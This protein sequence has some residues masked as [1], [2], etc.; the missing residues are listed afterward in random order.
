MPKNLPSLWSSSECAQ[1][2]SRG[3]RV[4]LECIVWIA[5]SDLWVIYESAHSVL[6][7]C[8]SA[9]CTQRVCPGCARIV[10]RV[11]LDYLEP[12]LPKRDHLRYFR[13][14]GSISKH[15]GPYQ[16]S[17]SPCAITS[18]HLGQSVTVW[19]HLSPQFSF[20]RVYVHVTIFYLV[21]LISTLVARIVQIHM[22]V[23]FIF[24]STQFHISCNNISS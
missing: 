6:R 15:P 18:D 2:V 9:Q 5:L 23:K 4:C 1:S 16:T 20:L 8:T 3:C 21:D 10:P 17:C 14:F 19:D 13:P 12:S 22:H 11:C 24:I 7:V